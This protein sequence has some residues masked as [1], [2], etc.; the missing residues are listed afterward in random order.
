MITNRWISK[1]K[2]VKNENDLL[3]NL[4]E[5]RGIDKSKAEEFLK[6]QLSFLTSNENFT[7]MNQC[8]SL[9]KKFIEENKKFLIFGDYD[10]DG[11]TSTTILV[12]TFQNL[13]VDVQYYIPSRFT[14]GYGISK[15]ALKNLKKLD[16]DVL[17]SVD[18]G[19]TSMEEVDLLNKMGKEVII[20]DH[21]NVPQK[22]PNALTILNPKLDKPTDNHY[23]L[24]G[25]GVAYMLSKNLINDESI[26]NENLQLA[27]IGTIA[28]IVP[29]KD[30]NRIIASV[31]IESIKKSPINGLKELIE[32]SGIELSKLNTESIGYIISPRLNAIGRLSYASEAVELF[33][34]QNVDARNELANKLNKINSDRKNIQEKIYNE[35]IDKISKNSEFLKSGI[36]TV[37]GND[38]HEGVIGIVASKLVDL[39]KK[40][41]IVFTNKNGILKGSARSVEGYSIYDALK[42]I[43]DLYEN[44]G[45][46]DQA[47]GLTLK[48][49]NFN[50]FL[51]RLKSY[52]DKNLTFEILSPKKYFDA[53][54][55]PS[56][57]NNSTFDLISKF[58]PFGT[59]NPKFTFKSENLRLAY[60]DVVG[61]NKNCL[62]LNLL[63]NNRVIPAIMF[64]NTNIK[65]PKKNQS[66]DLLYDISINTFKGVSNLQLI[67]DD[68]RIYSKNYTEFH[69]IIF[70]IYAEKLLNKFI[71]NEENPIYKLVY[72]N[73]NDVNYLIENKQKILVHNF[74]DYLKLI[75]S[76]I[77]FGFTIN[78]WSDIKNINK[79]IELFENS[80][81]NNISKY[82]IFDDEYKDELNDIL[83][84][85]YFNRK[86]FFTIYNYIKKVKKVNKFKLA[87]KSE[88]PLMTLI[89]LE[90]FKEAGFIKIKDNIVSLV[91]G[92]H[93]KFTFENSNIYKKIIKFTNFF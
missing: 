69:K 38:W 90:F 48:L 57:I 46:H 43:N 42:H 27:A 91:F 10:V 66:I 13:G 31:G 32:V 33:L 73:D 71:I 82:V 37:Y 61:K 76:F 53:I 23:Y 67:V 2:F 86:Y 89:C 1:E 9:I 39:Y 34:S 70:T 62:K 84:E 5:I 68:F 92:E 88:K 28:D 41:A 14:E 64:N 78:S 72:N 36:V 29:L 59:D 24:C 35:A 81:K 77:D 50:E 4:L 63:Y 51:E 16:F 3:S 55:T 74:T 11:I 87:Y 60:A 80:N 8:V 52:N 65:V 45:G 79:Y 40:P 75:Y 44:F 49:L 85:L 93:N 19:I 15:N 54:I 47:L 25:A 6:P 26:L 21:H 12:K 58:E 56:Y 83:D 17:I 7:N 18:C 20:T 30:D 22:L